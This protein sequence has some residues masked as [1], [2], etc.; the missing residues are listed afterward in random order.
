MPDKIS[1]A[2]NEHS[3]TTRCPHCGGQVDAR[4]IIPPPS[5]PT[6]AELLQ[7]AQAIYEQHRILMITEHGVDAVAMT[8]WNLAGDHVHAGWLTYARAAFK[9]IKGLPNL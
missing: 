4:I 8:E 1:T 7:V 2:I 3:T 5:P 6:D 9:I